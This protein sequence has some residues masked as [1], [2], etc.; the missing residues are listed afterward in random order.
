MLYK[1]KANADA[2]A[3]AKAKAKVRRLSVKSDES[4]TLRAPNSG[5]QTAGTEKALNGF[6]EKSF[7]NG[8]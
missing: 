2:E 8:G 7:V 6:F 1:P 4:S 5:K 3:K